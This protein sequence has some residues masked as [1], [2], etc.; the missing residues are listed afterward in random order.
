MPVLTAVDLCMRHA[1]RLLSLRSSLGGVQAVSVCLDEPAPLNECRF[2]AA[3]PSVRRLVNERT[4]IQIRVP[5][6]AGG[7]NW[8]LLKQAAGVVVPKSRMTTETASSAWR[9]SI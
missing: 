7:A 8:A 3:S 1:G 9:A 2:M 6:Q 5:Y 4:K